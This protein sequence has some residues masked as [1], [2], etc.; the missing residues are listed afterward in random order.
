MVAQ[1]LTRQEQVSAGDSSFTG[2][3]L[4]PVKDKFKGLVITYEVLRSR[5]EVA[6]RPAHCVHFSAWSTRSYG[7]G[8][9]QDP[10]MA[11]SKLMVTKERAFLAVASTIGTP[12]PGR[13]AWLRC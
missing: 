3:T 2:A 11:E 6:E 7:E 5:T 1:T 4:A 10:P 13:S 8:L 12:S 9:L